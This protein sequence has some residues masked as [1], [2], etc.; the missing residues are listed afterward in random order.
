MITF[1][2]NIIFILI[3]NRN[4]LVTRLFLRIKILSKKECDILITLILYIID[5]L[6]DS[7]RA[8]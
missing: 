1:I 5:L 7:L 6:S 8:R 2:E 3:L 4:K